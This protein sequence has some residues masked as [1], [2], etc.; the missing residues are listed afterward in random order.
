MKR[1][2]IDEIA[3]HQGQGN[4]LVVLVDLDTHKPI[5]LVKSRKQVDIRS[6]MENWG[7]QVRERIQ[8]VS[9]DMSGNYKSLVRTL[10]PNADIT[11]D[12]FQVMQTL[13]SELNQARIQV[14][15][16]G[17]QLKEP[18]EKARIKAA[19]SQSKYVLLKVEASLNELQKEQLKSLK[20]VAPLLAR[21]HQLKENFR[22]IFETAQNLSDGTL[23]LLDWLLDAQNDLPKTVGTIT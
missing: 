16:A 13:N 2:G 12:R 4:F 7:M 21:K 9:I 8:E 11:V 10:L 15:K 19:L 18:A 3:L 14:I 17:E 20:Q 23:K 5:A 22:E 1:L 6:L